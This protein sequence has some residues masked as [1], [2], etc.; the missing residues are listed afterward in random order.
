MSFLLLAGILVLWLIFQG[1]PSIDSLKNYQP[2]QSTQVYDRNNKK[3]GRFYDELRTVVPISELP[4]YVK[5]AF[6]A[7]EDGNFYQHGGID[8]F[9]LMR[10][11]ALE[12]KHKTVGGRRVG[13][14]TITQ[15]TARTM[16]LTSRQTYIRK[17][18]EII[19][20]HRIEQALDKDEILHL[21][22]N[23]IYFGNGAYGIE[24]A[25]QM[26]FLKS[27]R[28][29]SLFEAAAL[30]STPKSPNR[31]NP[32]ADLKRLKI[33]QAYVLERMVNQG[34]ITAADAKDAQNM[35]LFSKA[36]QKK[37]KRL[38]PYFLKAVKSELY[39]KK[40]D[41]THLGAMSVYSTLDIELQELAES[42]LR[43][44]LRKIDKR[45][46][47]RG[48]L[49]RPG[50]EHNIKIKNELNLFR[51]DAFNKD[52]N[53]IW[54]LRPLAESLVKSQINESKDIIR[55]T[56][57]DNEVLV[58]VRISGVNDRAGYAQVDLGS[59]YGRINFTDLAWVKSK[60]ISDILKIGDIVLVNVSYS[61][62]RLAVRLE[63]E[64]KI[65]GGLVSL[66]IES[67]GILALVGGYDYS[68][69]SFNR[70]FQAKRQPGS[71]IKPLIYALALEKSHVTAA[72]IITDT[73]KAFFDP[74][75]N[76]FW[77]PRN[78]NNRYLGDITVRRCLRSS[79]NICTLT[80]LQKI[81]LS[82]F[83]AFAKESELSG[84]S[85]P[86]PKNLTIALGSAEVIPINIANALRAIANKGVYSPYYMIDEIAFSD[87]GKEKLNELDSRSLL[88]SSSAFIV[89]NILQEVISGA[90][91]QRHLPDVKAQLA[92]KTGT[93]NEARSA[94]FFGYSPK[95]FTLVFVGYDDNRSIG[96]NEWGIT[97]AFPIWAEFMN[98]I[99]EHQSE[100]DFDVPDSIEW[101]AITKN[102]GKVREKLNA[103]ELKEDEI[104]EAFIAGTAPRAVP[105]DSVIS[106]SP[107]DL[108]ESAFAP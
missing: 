26:Y 89:T 86:M 31:I 34:F 42:V 15:Q 69:S 41:T 70:I 55:V 90:R 46:G 16:L 52:K 17:I 62:N 44:G 40:G 96:A 82:K 27:A 92:G 106:S 103:E 104:L 36:A 61:R 53:R 71:T 20:A 9:G 49:F 101:H 14:S 21:Y 88:S 91:W 58:G 74:G 105:Y 4:D 13:G 99:E 18:K 33:R 23:Q 108:G 39:K 80:L 5:L 102:S 3:I 37:Q 10:A 77:R 43:N 63:Q 85:T 67:G 30:A 7:A 45:S 72:S 93:T 76:E 54:D 19:L 65:N 107:I 84:G 6:V 51:R 66:D 11:I 95:I 78:H 29:L 81:G 38:A 1:L 28:E 57:L 97:T 94:W 47:Y 64:P 75:T 56:S 100:L 32:F 73:P 59:M 12:V 50:K 8:Y 83:L 2:L 98:G 25:A 87:G 48:P 60:R 79:I 68:R 24:E 35:P 22:L